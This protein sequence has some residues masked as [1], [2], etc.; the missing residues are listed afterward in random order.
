MTGRPRLAVHGGVPVRRTMLPYGRQMVDEEDIQSV[1]NVLQSDWLT[2]GP[3]LELFEESFTK[4]VGASHAVALSSGTAALHASMAALGIGPGDEVIVP[5]MTFAA[6]ANCILYRGGTPVLVDVEP[7]TL[8]IDVAAVRDRITPRTRAVIAVDYAGH[9]AD[10]DRLHEVCRHQNIPLVADACH[11]LGGRYKGRSV[12]S[13]ATLNTF[14]FHP[15]K[16]IAT[17]EGGMVTTDDH[18]LAQSIR[19]FR[20][21]GITS[22]HRRRAEQGSWYYEM[23]DLGYNYRLSDIACALGTSQLTKLDRWVERRRAI[24]GR[25]REAFQDIQGIE[26]LEESPEVDHAYHLF[27]VRLTDGLEDR[28]AEIFS[29]LRAEGI[30][31]NVH[32][33]PVHLHPYY[34]KTLGTAPGQFPVAEDAYRRILSLPIFPAMT[35]QDVSDVIASVRKVVPAFR[36]GE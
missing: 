9:P 35:D 14:S 27:V 30:G 11:A 19:F 23:V 21:H 10:Y 25:Y 5:V 15:V 6:T 7:A 8:L 33:V 20:N 22:D 32:Y 18:E 31:V 1:V 16:H 34:R 2:T 4:K 17:G 26:P 29:A 3:A 36:R 24:A 13:L 28:R 12:G